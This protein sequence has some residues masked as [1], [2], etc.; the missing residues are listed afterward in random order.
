MSGLDSAL[1]TVGMGFEV[2][3]GLGSSGNNRGVRTDL[4]Q[5]VNHYIGLQPATEPSSYKTYLDKIESRKHKSTK[6]PLLLVIG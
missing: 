5:S 4:K 1:T 3:E 6:N 2:A